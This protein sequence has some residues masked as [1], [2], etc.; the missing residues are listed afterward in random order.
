[1]SDVEIDELA[2]DI[3]KNGLLEPIII[4]VDNRKEANGAKPPFSQYLLDGRNRLEALRRLGITGPHHK[5]PGGGVRYFNAIKQCVGGKC[6]WETDTDPEVYVLSAN[7]HR[8]HLTTEQ[9]H[10]AIAAFI[11]ADPK[12]S[13]SRIAKTLKVV[14]DKTVAKV[15]EKSV[16]NPDTPKNEHLPIERA[17][18]AV[19]ANPGAS[20]REIAKIADV[21]PA[22]VLRAQKLIAAEPKEKPE[23]APE[24]KSELE[25]KLSVID[26]ERETQKQAQAFREKVQWT[27][28]SWKKQFAEGIGGVDVMEEIVTEEASRCFYEEATPSRLRLDA[29]YPSSLDSSGNIVSNDDPNHGKGDER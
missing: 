2:K 7:V 1:M 6:S 10:E 21:V 8:R 15:R 18:T 9:K 14:S 26:A 29:L 13:D 16:Q 3:E 4:W 12:A 11:K 5:R 25:P 24:Q 27:F 28:L 23:P 17:K 22:T 19:R 20:T